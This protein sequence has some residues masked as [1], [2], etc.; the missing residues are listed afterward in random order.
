[1]P[2]SHLLQQFTGNYRQLVHLD[3][4]FTEMKKQTRHQYF[5][6]GGVGN[7]LTSETTTE[8]NI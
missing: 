5:F 4:W 2:N 3:I 1:M 7:E 6:K 8:N